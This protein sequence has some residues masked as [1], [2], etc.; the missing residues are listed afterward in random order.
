MWN[1][2][3]DTSKA[4]LQAK[5]VEL[6]GEVQTVR[7]SLKPGGNVQMAWVLLREGSDVEKI[8]GELDGSVVDGV[9]VRAKRDEPKGGGDE[10]GSRG[11]GRRKPR[12]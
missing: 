6:G 5:V 7:T 10:A 9:R 12:N 8:V 1:V 2:G 4:Q 3:P 11:L